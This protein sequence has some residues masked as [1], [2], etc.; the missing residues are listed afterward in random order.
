MVRT[1]L[2]MLHALAGDWEALRPWLAEDQVRVLR[3]LHTALAPRLRTAVQA[4][5]SRRVLR[6][7]LSEFCESLEHFN[8]RWEE[9]LT[10]V[11]LTPVNEVRDGYNRYYLLE[12]EC[13]MRSSAL[14]QRGFHRL[15]PLTTEHVTAALPPLPVPRLA[16]PV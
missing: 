15:E 7:A 14:A 9:F 2:A 10:S 11:D 12:K 3:D 6:R 5:T 8:R 13:A 16:N 4:T 1:R